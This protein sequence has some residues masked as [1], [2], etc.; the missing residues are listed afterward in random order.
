MS[1]PCE[2]L[3][4]TA[5]G[6]LAPKRCTPRT[7]TAWSDK[8][9]ANEI[10]RG[11]ANTGAE[12]LFTPEINS[13]NDPTAISVSATDADDQL[14]V[15]AVL[16]EI[17][18]KTS[19]GGRTAPA[20]AIFGMNFQSVSVAEKLVDPVK[21]CARNQTSTCDPGYVRGGYLPGSLAFTPQMVSAM[22]YV[23]GAI[24]SMA[25]ALQTH[26]LDKSTEI[27]I[28]AKHAQSP[29]D[30]AKLSKIGDQVSKVLSGAGIHI[31]QTTTD[32]VAHVGSRISRRR[33]PRSLH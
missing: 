27:I 17:D 18:D 29:I 31:A 26:N 28:S 10:V 11:P 16:N 30:P 6:L 21:S 33:A 15:Q 13:V 22:T 20:P 24:G 9:P 1:R 25:H 7:W 32:D 19:D 3:A 5:P 4:A 12:D 2:R 23:D 14:K 8:H